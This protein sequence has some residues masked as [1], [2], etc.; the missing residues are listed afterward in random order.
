MRPSPHGRTQGSPGHS[1]NN[2]DDNSYLPA[3]AG[4]VQTLRKLAPNM[5]QNLLPSPSDGSACKRLWMYLRWMIRKDAVDPGGWNLSPSKLIVPIDTH[6]FALGR[7]LK[8]TRR[9]Q[10]NLQTAIEMTKRF[11]QISLEDPV[12][13]DFALTRL[14]IR[15]ELDYGYLEIFF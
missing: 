15:A 4:F 8:L 1:K 14:G 13:Y 6:M 9:K 5:R 12:K 10:A 7:N 2:N 11:K 3:L